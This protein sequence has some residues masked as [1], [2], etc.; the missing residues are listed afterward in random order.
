MDDRT[1]CEKTLRKGHYLQ[2][3]TPINVQF[4]LQGM[5]DKV[6]FTFSVGDVRYMGYH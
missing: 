6:R 1:L 2:H 4:L 5:I 3:C